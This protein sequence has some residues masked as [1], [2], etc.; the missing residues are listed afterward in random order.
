[1]HASSDW[2]VQSEAVQSFQQVHM[3]APKHVNFT[4]LVPQLVTH[5]SSPHLLLRQSSIDC[6]RQLCQRETAQVCS[7]ARESQVKKLILYYSNKYSINS[8]KFN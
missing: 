8:T 1:M 4:Q 6:L 2:I 5:L 3:F 7:I